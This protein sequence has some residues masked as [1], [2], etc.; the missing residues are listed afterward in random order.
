MVDV[1]RIGEVIA[2]GAVN[3]LW[4]TAGLFQQVVDARLD[5]LG[6]LRWLVAGGDA[7]SV[8]HICRALEHWPD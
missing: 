3:T 2:A 8:P 7:L 6:S 4:L 1:Q 5:T